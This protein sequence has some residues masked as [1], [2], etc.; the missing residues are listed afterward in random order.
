[1]HDLI[2]NVSSVHVSFVLFNLPRHFLSFGETTDFSLMMYHL[3]RLKP[4]TLL[5]STAKSH[6]AWP[7]P[8]SIQSTTDGQKTAFFSFLL[9]RFIQM[10]ATIRKK[11]YRYFCYI[12]TLIENSITLSL[13]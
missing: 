4:T 9:I 13:K 1:M 8:A 10:Y 2:V 12:A 11:I 6:S 3:L 5:Q 7:C